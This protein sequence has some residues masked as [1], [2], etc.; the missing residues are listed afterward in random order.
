MFLL[1]IDPYGVDCTTRILNNG[2][3]QVMLNEDL[4]PI[5]LTREELELLLLDGTCPDKASPLKIAC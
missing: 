5:H 4:L 2:R 1:H 3:F